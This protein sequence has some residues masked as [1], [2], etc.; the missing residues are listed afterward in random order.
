MAK[1]MLSRSRRINVATPATRRC[2][3]CAKA[4]PSERMKWVADLR[5]PFELGE[6]RFA[7]TV[8][9]IR[10][11]TVMM[12]ALLVLDPIFEADSAAGEQYAY[13]KDRQRTGRCKEHVH[14]LINT[15]HV[16]IVD[17][18]LTAYFDTPLSTL[19]AFR[20]GSSPGCRRSHASSRIK[21]WLTAPVE[22][23]DERGRK[24]REYAES[25]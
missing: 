11:R 24:H 3:L 13:R 6:V 18:D 20:V 14:K 22:E 9:A 25:G 1:P 21:M 23:T 8:P 2:Q 15:G 7:L 10:D 16:E 4:V 5:H 12:A 19:R 17:A